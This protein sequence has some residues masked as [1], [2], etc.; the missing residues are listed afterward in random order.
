MI[1]LVIVCYDSERWLERCLQTLFA[2]IGGLNLHCLLVDN[3]QM[4]RDFVRQLQAQF[5][6][7]AYHRTG[8]NLFYGGGNNIGIE[9][10]LAAG[11]EYIALI[12]PDTWFPEGWLQA[13]MQCFE[14]LPEYGILAPLQY[15]YEQPDELAGW[16]KGILRANSVDNLSQCLIDLPYVEGSCLFARAS[17][18]EAVGGFDPLFEMYYEEIDLCRRARFAGFKVGLCTKSKY[19]HHSS[20]KATGEA[21]LR[22]N[23]RISLSQLIYTLTA[24]EYSWYQ[25]LFQTT[26][27]AIKRFLKTMPDSSFPSFQFLTSATGLLLSQYKQLK[28]KWSRD[29]HHLLLV[30]P[31]YEE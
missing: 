22:R 28:T 8:A 4:D 2:D 7:L 6:G 18:I 11:A 17:V 24:P 15:D 19:H 3:G 13:L 30:K 10:G 27:W 20:R 12:N 26:K 5:P 31:V 23:L 16:T 29:R 25:N 1:Y 21:L 14:N 9:K